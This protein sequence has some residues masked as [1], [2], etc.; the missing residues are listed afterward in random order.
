M[1]SNGVFYSI[2]IAESSMAV[3]SA[4]LFKQGKWK[5]QKI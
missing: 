1:H 5:K 3:V 4:I 2:A